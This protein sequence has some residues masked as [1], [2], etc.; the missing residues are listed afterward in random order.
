MRL[1]VCETPDRIKVGH[2]QDLKTC[3]GYKPVSQAEGSR[4]GSPSSRIS[5]VGQP[6]RHP[7]WSLLP[8]SC[9]APDAWSSRTVSSPPLCT[10]IWHTQ[11]NSGK[12][13]QPQSGFESLWE[14]HWWWVNGPFKQTISSQY[15]RQKHFWLL[16]CV[17][18]WKLNFIHV[19]DTVKH[20]G[21]TTL[22]VLLAA[23]LISHCI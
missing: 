7:P 1:N 21:H 5:W 17:Q 16:G 8:A 22:P 10:D 12:L 9:W 2:V 3:R 18:P 23:A 20:A 4:L 14:D 11:T 15:L 6:W 19:S 13:H